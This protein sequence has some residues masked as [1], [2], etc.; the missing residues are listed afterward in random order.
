M[1]SQKLHPL[2][3]VM[4]FQLWLKIDETSTFCRIYSPTDPGVSQYKPSLGEG[5]QPYKHFQSEDSWGQSRWIEAKPW[6]AEGYELFCS[7]K[8]QN[9]NWPFL[10]LQIKDNPGPRFVSETLFLMV[11]R[12]HDPR[13]RVFQFKSCFFHSFGIISLRISFLQIWTDL[14]SLLRVHL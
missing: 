1:S 8:N 2:L 12:I 3:R 13:P 4:F 11:C 6:L 7:F 5:R 14:Q 9:G 10:G